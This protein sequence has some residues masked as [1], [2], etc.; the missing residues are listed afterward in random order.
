MHALR[1]TCGC[2]FNLLSA[3]R[4]P[5]ETRPARSKSLPFT[6]DFI[7]NALKEKRAL[8]EEVSRLKAKL[9]RLEKP[10]G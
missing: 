2:T 6:R 10:E 4:N 7:D 8:A 9:S 3:F 5:L 1:A